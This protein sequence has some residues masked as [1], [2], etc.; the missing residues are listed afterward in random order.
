MGVP[1]TFR[2]LAFAALLVFAGGTTPARPQSFDCS[3]ASLPAEMTVCNDGMLGALD[4]E[5]SR[6][7]FRLVNS[8]PRWAVVEIRREQ[9]EWLG[10]RDACGTDGQCLM[11]HY[12][13]RTMGL[14]T[15]SERLGLAT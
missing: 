10:S 6:L 11:G 9:R 15:W 14:Y 4:E 8:A 2:S 3:R 13:A 1:M 5:M 7:Y 12:R